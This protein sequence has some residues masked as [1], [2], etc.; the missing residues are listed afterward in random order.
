[1]MWPFERGRTYSRRLDIH[2]KYGGQQQGGII[3][4]ADQPLVIVITG[5]AG[6]QH[7]YADTLRPDGVFEYFGEGQL[8]ICV[9]RRAILRSN[10]IRETVKAFFYSAKRE[11]GPYAMKANGC[12][13][14]CKSA[15]R[16]TGRAIYDGRMSLSS[17]RWK[18]SRR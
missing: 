13:R 15:K 12:V 14:V 11:T 6:E 8:A 1:M 2:G 18:Q 7:G 4:P 9:W 3:T 5:D 17:A 10:L 16:Q